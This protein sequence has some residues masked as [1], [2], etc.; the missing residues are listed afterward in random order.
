[1]RFEPGDAGRLVIAI[2]VPLLVGGLTGLATAESVST[3]YTTINTPAWTPPDAVFGPVW[4]TLYVLM[5]LALWLVWRHGLDQPVVRTA[6]VLFAV[7]LLLNFLWSL[8]FFGL[9]NP[10]LALI[11]IVALWAF[12]LATTVQ[13]FRVQPLAGWL[14][15]PYLLWVSFATALNAAIWQINR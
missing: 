14:L 4:T 5:G 3:W 10:A 2:I 9:H 13:C 12:V 8:I 11:D 6:V 7:Q 15:V 1:M